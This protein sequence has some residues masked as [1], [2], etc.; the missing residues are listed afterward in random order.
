MP[1]PVLDGPKFDHAMKP[2]LLVMMWFLIAMFA[3][4]AGL[5]VWALAHHDHDK[6]RLMPVFTPFVVIP[7][8]VVPGL[9]PRWQL[10][11]DGLYDLR[12][13]IKKG[14]LA[15]YGEIQSVRVTK[16][17]RNGAMWFEISLRQG[18]PV[19]VDVL[20]GQAFQQELDARVPQLQQA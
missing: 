15:Y 17:R 11:P 19:K 3:V 18:K 7:A 8:I 10:A 4:E 2:F 16:Q 20:N 9:R 6:V 13:N 1:Q 14:P 12:R 5:I